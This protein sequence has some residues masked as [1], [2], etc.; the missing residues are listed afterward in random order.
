MKEI[1]VIGDTE[2]GCG[3]LHDDFI[4]DKLLSKLIRSLAKKKHPVELVL[5]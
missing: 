1:I 3:D 4:S 2:L 5:N